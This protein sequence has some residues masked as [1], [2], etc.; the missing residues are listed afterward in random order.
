[1]KKAAV[2]ALFL[3]IVLGFQSDPFALLWPSY[4][5]KPA[6][7]FSKHSVNEEQVELGRK[8]FYDP[9][10]SFDSSTSCA[11]CHSPFN[12]FAHVDHKL[13]HG[14]YDSIGKRNA[15]A[16]FNLAWQ[17]QFMWDGAVSNLEVQ[18]LAPIS[19][20]IEMHEDIA[21]V[22]VKLQRSRTYPS[23]FQSAFG[24]STITGQ[25]VLLALTQFQLTLMS[26]NSKYDSV[27]QKTAKFTTQEENGYRLFKAH[28]NVCHR[29]PLFSTY[30]FASNG[31]PLDTYLNDYGRFSITQQAKDSFLFKIPSLRNVEYTY[32][33][34]HDGRFEKLYDVVS[35]YSGGIPGSTYVSA[36]LKKPIVLSAAEKIDLVAFLLTLS[37]KKFIFNPR[38]GPPPRN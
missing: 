11:S 5:P 12:A 14:I 8:L 30:R 2:G 16:L 1:M 38:F 35:Y 33:F 22:T 3:F 28:C 23:L 17:T 37:D 32:P 7:D 29:E 18:P 21:R 24:D 19:S 20:P 36:E 27:M 13:S 6:Y 31:L 15:P 26:F 10:L 34:M 4:F 25:N 9:V